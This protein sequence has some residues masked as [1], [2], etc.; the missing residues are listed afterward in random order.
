M[1]HGEGDGVPGLV[2]D[3]YDDVAVIQTSTLGMEL[4]LDS[5]VDAVKSVVKPKT[6]L[7]NNASSSRAVEQLPAYEKCVYGS[8]P[9]VLNITENNA[10]VKAY[11][12]V[13]KLRKI[14]DE[15]GNF[16]ND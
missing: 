10:K 13:E 2:V 5:I 4:L 8:M 3:V 1:V 7:I 9:D 16:N 6:I 12:I 14:L 15:Q 11:R